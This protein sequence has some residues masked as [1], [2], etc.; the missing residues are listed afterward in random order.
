[1]THLLSGGRYQIY[2]LLY[3]LIWMCNYKYATVLG[4]KMSEEHFSLIV[5]D[6]STALFRVD[7]SGRYGNLKP[8]KYK[9]NFSRFNF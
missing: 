3:I 4:A 6:S 2:G 5:V 8:A 1:M 9:R 7:F